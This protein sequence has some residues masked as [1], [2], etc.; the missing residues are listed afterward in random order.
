MSM[1]SPVAPES[2]RALV[3]MGAFA[4]YGVELQWDVSSPAECCR[5]YEERG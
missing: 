4:V 3:D 5:V 1:N 2:I